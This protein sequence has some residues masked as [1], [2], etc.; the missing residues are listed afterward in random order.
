MFTELLEGLKLISD[1]F[2]NLFLIELGPLRIFV[3]VREVIAV[4]VAHD[5]RLIVEDHTIYSVRQTVSKVKL[6]MFDPLVD[7]DL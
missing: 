1:I 5:L 7:P 4:R 2:G 6:L 3:E